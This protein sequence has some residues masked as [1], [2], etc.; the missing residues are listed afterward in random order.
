VLAGV[1]LLVAACGDDGTP[2][3]PPPVVSTLPAPGDWRL[4]FHDEFEDSELD[5]GRWATCY[6][7]NQDG[8]T[9]AGNDEQQWYL[10][11][12]VSVSGGRLTLTAERRTTRGSDGRTYPWVSGMISTGRDHWNARPR[13]TFTYGYFEAA[14]RIPSQDGMFPAFWMMPET[15]YTPPELDIMEF[16]D[17]TR[18]VSMY[19]HWRDR[20]GAKRKQ[21]GTYGPA[22]FPGEYHVFAL[23]WEADELT[24]YVDGVERFKVTDPDRIPHIPMEILVNLAVGVPDA[25]ARSVGSATMRANWVRVWQH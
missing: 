18:H 19:T 20:E 21:K 25:P 22:D 8:C 13:R 7:W 4:V 12:Q 6:D 10:P 9:N 1:L 3:K 14:I 24:W 5:T 16:L 2:P 11:G 17:T 15:R 23:L